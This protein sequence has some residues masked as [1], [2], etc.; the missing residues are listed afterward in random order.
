MTDLEMTKRWLSNDLPS[1][2]WE[3]DKEIG[4]RMWLKND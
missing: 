3:Y 4:Q 2:D 1:T